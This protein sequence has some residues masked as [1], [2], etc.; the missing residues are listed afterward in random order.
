VIV[1]WGKARKALFGIRPAEVTF[2]RR[3][4][5]A[6]GGARQRLEQIGRTFLDGYHAALEESDPQALAGRLRGAGEEACGFAFEG[7]AMGLALLDRLTPWRADRLGAFLRGPGAPHAYMV[8]VGAGWAVARL[9]G[10]VVRLG[11]TLDPVLRWLVYDGC[12]FHEG[13]FRWRRCVA[14]RAVPRYATGYARR[15][16]DQGLGRSLWFVCGADIAAIARTIEEFPPAR[17]PDLWSGVGLAAAYAGGVGARA[18]DE[19]ARASGPSRPQFA[20]G[21][22]FAAKARQRAGNP[23]G[24]TELACRA[25]CGLSAAAA[26]RV[27]DDALAGLAAEEA[28]PAYEVWRRRIQGF[29]SGA[30]GT[31][32]GLG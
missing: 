28:E 10:R 19:L 17:R 20:Q 3:G 1:P 16:F 11:G 23:A 27:T 26:A 14:G 4:F 29:F 8:H 15:A 30:P 25:V 9:G 18:L 32:R 24:H 13:Y 7:A 5:R 21:V 12:G 31:A 2:A 22:A 6:A